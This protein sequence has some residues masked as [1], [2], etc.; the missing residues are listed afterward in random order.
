MKR[1][2][3]SGGTAT[4]APAGPAKSAAPVEHQ[5][6]GQ[7]KLLAKRMAEEKSRARTV[8]RGQAVAEKLSAATEQVSSAITEA[9]SAV[10]ELGKTMQT[11]GAGAEQ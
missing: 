9:S 11:I 2:A 7:S 1:M 6:A 4:A 5:D 8:A 10:E 3:P